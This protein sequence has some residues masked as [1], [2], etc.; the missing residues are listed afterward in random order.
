[1]DHLIYILIFFLG[2]TLGGL[3]AWAVAKSRMGAQLTRC[4][5][6]SGA[7]I[8]RLQEVI[9]GKEA[10]LANQNNTIADLKTKLTQAEA[11]ILKISEERSAAKAKLEQMKDVQKALEEKTEEVRQLNTTIADFREKKAE[12]ET[13]VEQERTAAEEKLKLLEEAKEKLTDTFKAL[14]AATLKNSNESFLELAK[15]TLSKYQEEAKKDLELRQKEVKEIVAPIKESLEKYDRQIQEMERVRNRAYGGL[16]EQVQSLLT[17]QHQLQRETANLV[18]ALRTPQ[19]RGRW[20]EIT[21][22]RVAELAGMLNYCDFFEQETR[23]TED[24][25]LRP[26]MIVR[27]PNNRQIVVDSKAPLLAY[28]EALEV[29]TEEER[30]RKLI[31]HSKQ[32]QA[33]MNKLSQKTYWDQF[34]PTPEFVVLFIPGENFFSSALEHNPGLIEEGVSKGVILATPT[35]LISLLKAVAFGW[36][37]EIMAENAEIISNL[38]KELY[39]RISTMAEHLD[40]LGRNIEKCVS[41]YNQVVGSFERRVLASARKFSELGINKRDG[42]EIPH[43]APVEKTT[44]Q[45][46]APEPNEQDPQS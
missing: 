36:R 21:L 7:E 29:Q 42:A 14:S 24:G 23:G 26:D 41:S 13:I 38:G 22:R 27:L 20:G 3:V 28:L 46:S 2:C 18:K 39:V 6:Q 12:L 32:I 4:L 31:L 34:Q 19:V 44:R 1:M 5:T 9:H 17:T 8:A 45:I 16:S 33:H 10:E 37:Q 11:N 25:R 35:T 43:I 30:K 15:V 40:R